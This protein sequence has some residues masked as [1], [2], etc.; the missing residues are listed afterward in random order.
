MEGLKDAKINRR[1]QK[2]ALTRS[3]KALN[4]LIDGQRP[5]KEVSDY[6]TKYQAC[7]ERLVE[8]HE[9]YVKLIEDDEQFENEEEWLTECQE[10]FMQ[11]E[12][13][14]KVYVETT[15]N[16]GKTAVES[17]GDGKLPSTS[18]IENV[19]KFN[20]MI[21]MQ[22][23]NQDVA[24]MSHGDGMI[25]MSSVNI[26]LTDKEKGPTVDKS[27]NS[28]NT[29]T[30]ANDIGQTK[31]NNTGNGTK[32]DGD[33]T[34]ANKN[35][36]K[37]D[38]DQ[39]S[40]SNPNNTPTKS[41]TTCNFKIEK[42]K[43][44]TFDGDVREYA[45]FKADFK[46]AVESHFNDRDAITFLRT[47]LREKPLQLIKGIGTDYKAAWNYLDAIYGDPRFVSD[48]IIQ[49]I[50]RFKAL[51]QGEDARFCEL[52][53]LVNRSYNTLK[54][55]G[56][57]NDMNNSHMLAVI[58]R[59]MCGDDLKVWSREIERQGGVATLEGL[60]NW[61]TTEMKLRM[62]ATAPL[63]ANV[64]QR[65]IHHVI[66]DNYVNQGAATQNGNPN[67][68]RFK[69]WQCKSSTHWPDQCQKLAQ[70]T[71]EERLATAKRNHVCFSCLKQAGR[72][73]RAANCSRRRKCS[74][75][76]NGQECGKY[77]HPLLHN[78][79]SS[80]LVG[81][82]TSI[83]DSNAILPTTTAVLNG[84]KGLRKNGNVLLDSGAQI[85]LIRNETATVLGLSGKDTSISLRKVGGEEEYIKTKVYKVP[86]SSMDTGYT[87]S[88]QAIGIPEISEVTSSADLK[89]ILKL[90][91]LEKERVRRG[92]GPIDLLIG[93]D[94]AHLHTGQTKQSGEL[95]AR[96]TPLGWVVFGGNSS[97]NMEDENHVYHVFYSETVDLSAFWKTE[98]MGVE[99]KPCVCDADKISQVERQEA[100]TISNSCQKVGTQW[101]IS[102]PWKKDPGL[103]PDNKAVAEK[104]LEATER[105][106]KKNP[107]HAIAYDKQM[108]EMCEMKFARKLTEEEMKTY[109]GPVHYISHHAV[110]RPDSSS[111]PLR[112][113][114]NTSSSYQGHVLNDYWMKGPDLLNDL[115]GVLLR[116][117]EK[118]YA[119]IGD[120]SKMYHRILIPLSD[121]HVHRYMWRNMETDKPPDV[122][123]KNVLTFGD[124][125]APAMAQTALRKTAE[126]N[127]EEYPEASK[128]L[129]ENVYMDDICHSESTAAKVS[130]IADDL[131]KVL[132]NGG[133]HV[134]KWITN[135][136]TS[137]KDKEEKVLGVTWNRVSDVLRFKFQ[138]T[139]STHH[140][141][142]GSQLTKR[143]I[144]SRVARLFDPIGFTAPVVIR[145]K[146]GL[147]RLWQRGYEWD[148]LLEPQE[149][150]EWQEFFRELK[151]L[152]KQELPRCL[153]P[154]AA[155]GCPILCIFADASRDAFGACAYLRWQVE[156]GRYE[157]RFVAAKSRV[158]PLKELTIPRLELQA[159]VLASR[160]YQTI[161]EE[162]RLEFEK[163]ILFTDSMIVYCWI[164]SI[165]RSFKPF[166]SARVSEIQSNTDPSQWRHVP[167]ENNVADDVSRGTTV[168]ELSNRWV[169]G[170]D[171]LKREEAEW[172]NE[173]TPMDEKAEQSE[174]RK[175]K[176]CGATVKA[177]EAIDVTRFSSWRRLVRTTAWIMR[178]AE[179]IRRRRY[180]QEGREGPLDVQEL[181]KAELYWI[182]NAQ[183][184]L[185]TRHQKGEFKTLS[186][187][188]D[189]KGIL[190]VGGR[191]DNALISYDA[192]HPALLPWKHRVSYLVTAHTHMHGH[193]G[194]AATTAK[195][196][197]KYWIIK[198]NK[199]S[200]AV[201]K[202]C[203]F[204]RKLA[205]K[206]EEQLM[207]NLPSLRLAPHTPPF[208]YTSCDYFGPFVCKVSRNKTCKHYGVIFTCLNTRAVHLEMAEDCSG[209]VLIQV[210]RRFFAIRG[211]PAVIM[212]DNGTQMVGAER[213]LREAIQ[214]ID[215]T[216]LKEFCA[217]K[218]L[219]WIFTTP[220]AP[221]QNGCA[222][223]LVK[224]C[225]RALKVAV[226]EQRLSPL[227]L[228]TC[229][230]EA[231]NL[232]NQRPIG[233]I[234]KDPDDGSFLCP[235]D[236]L[237]G[238]AT[239][240]VPQGPFQSTNN[241][242][243]RVEFVQKIVDSFWKR[244]TRD[245]LP[246]LVPSK[247][248]LVERR[249][250]RI[251]DIVV[252]SDP[253][254]VRGKWIVGRI[255]EVYPG[256]D[257][258]VRN[259]KVKTATGEYSRPITKLSVIH[260]VKQADEN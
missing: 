233:W 28:A 148:Q 259:V 32:S 194:V 219:Q 115:F 12:L 161:Q 42:P 22:T 57:Q 54:E 67:K 97:L 132:Q 195:V 229:F 154:T 206:T 107:K 3:G 177:E 212:S 241:P 248:W 218:G 124:K 196:R 77:H 68:P 9:E 85:S 117:R 11:L 106:L 16:K 213:E 33:Q 43:L 109:H 70:L 224:T 165:P 149:A 190:R 110:E 173:T 56:N 159:A 144:L 139:L 6:L 231:A 169:N 126:E 7:Y 19:D 113:V 242:R 120:L 58:E 118:E 73:H 38:G 180:N 260:A 217:E 62:R 112:I 30:S 103:L 157:V 64:N 189:A 158:A 92:K 86:I 48:T 81:A 98:A 122:Y 245:V 254:A 151:Q 10:N 71:V 230:L 59:K 174:R 130:K 181:R 172:P 147:Q 210:L 228:Y 75:S 37:S 135:E 140:D 258:K 244:W 164:K 18:G 238:R 247:K 49:D 66:A 252:L 53:H 128:V 1:T 50:T 171:F 39:T 257:D 153:T 94:H 40:G 84:C 80:P 236:L 204:C 27:I 134:K 175:D 186:P 29:D 129:K 246:T 17:K 163:A 170:P 101:Q 78:S 203:V 240:E 5:A 162:S 227:E 168:Q 116:F 179:K 74:K 91:G 167:G 2:A 251:G 141:D 253:N 72:E 55:V 155:T 211:Y 138:G 111:T 13:N 223:A 47:C 102:Y 145:A 197:N 137:D 100:E 69:C 20:G 36:T 88:V 209:M 166:V 121:Q 250:V 160:L 90:L 104:K 221:H 215:A 191:V 127:K 41:A 45:I 226:G 207:A 89:P 184:E 25:G 205:H 199:L 256:K 188:I 187:F 52:V 222:E 185:V 182:K 44:P 46:H 61:M 26:D 255:T 192:K 96:N 87:Y 108:Q 200:K 214:S 178:L 34:L 136:L 114:F 15:L 51:Q 216:K 93:I 234:P 95:V 82:T 24:E 99:V 133:F 35:S 123:V 31:E 237:L 249:N 183:K 23:A 4:N 65:S 105:R 60:M 156:E 125:P 198:G 201:R 143:K 146:I 150:K 63:R 152:E 232:V 79:S 193:S 239:S 14:A 220:A 142:E 243:K 176:F 208:H 21:G 76:D 202:T 119:L 225:K 83:T 235:N 8:V 131:D